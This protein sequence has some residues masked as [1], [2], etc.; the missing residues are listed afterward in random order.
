MGWSRH[1][2]PLS[3]L[4]PALTR[5]EYVKINNKEKIFDFVFFDIR[6]NQPKIVLRA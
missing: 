3:G 4:N 2:T 1:F 6:P 5:T